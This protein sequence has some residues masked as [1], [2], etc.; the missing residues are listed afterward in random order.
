MRSPPVNLLIS[1]C[2]SSRA[3]LRA[4]FTPEATRSSS[5]VTS[6]SPVF[7]SSSTCCSILIE[8]TSCRP[9]AT[10]VT[11]PPPTVASTVFSPRPSCNSRSFSCIFWACFMILPKPLFIIAFLLADD[12]SLA[13]GAIEHVA[14]ACSA[15]NIK[16][17]STEEFECL[18]YDRCPGERGEGIR[19]WRSTASGG[20][21]LVIR[22][23]GIDDAH[24]HLSS[25]H[26]P[27]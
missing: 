3:L 27:H 14:A 11:I 9:F 7:K 2:T 1:C 16:D 12:F 23:R 15:S 10:T 18:T 21:R 22:L 25:H 8:T 13:H 6:S 26:R 4:A 19:R 20:G 17:P 24:S 5:I